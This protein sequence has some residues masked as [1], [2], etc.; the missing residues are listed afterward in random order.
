[1]PFPCCSPSSIHSPLWI[2][3][4][5]TSVSSCPSGVLHQH[6]HCQ[7]FIAEHWAQPGAHRQ[8]GPSPLSTAPIILPWNLEPSLPGI[9]LLPFPVFGTGACNGVYSPAGLNE[10]YPTSSQGWHTQK[11]SQRGCLGIWAG[12]TPKE[13]SRL[14]A[15]KTETPV[16]GQPGG[17]ALNKRE[18][19]SPWIQLYLKPDPPTPPP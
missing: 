4:P 15:A 7:N 14:V 12:L 2:Q 16:K 6:S 17:T 9:L 10:W 3:R 18:E 19:E 11:L 1:M 13:T 8:P 5:S